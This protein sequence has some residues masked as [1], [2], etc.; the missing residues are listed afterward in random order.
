MIDAAAL[1]LNVLKLT[2]LTSGHELALRDFT[3]LVGVDRLQH[4]AEFIE[5]LAVKDALVAHVGA[6]SHA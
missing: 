5:L 3:V 1:Q 4:A 6:V 2:F